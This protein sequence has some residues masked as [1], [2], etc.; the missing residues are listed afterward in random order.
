MN[1]PSLAVGRSLFL[2]RI[3]HVGTSLSRRNRRAR[4][5]AA[6]AVMNDHGLRDLG[7]WR[8][9]DSPNGYLARF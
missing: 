3:A 4:D 8:E 7:L 1:V 6:V 5:F 9:R 2:E